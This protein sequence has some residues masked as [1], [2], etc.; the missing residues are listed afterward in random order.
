MIVML[1]RIVCI[2]VVLGGWGMGLI[3]VCFIVSDFWGDFI[4]FSLQYINSIKTIV[5]P[6]IYRVELPNTFQ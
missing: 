4:G 3:C 2:I 5:P 1:F 6:N